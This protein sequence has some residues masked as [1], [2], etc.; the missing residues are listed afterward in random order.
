MI[1]EMLY[2]PDSV[3]YQRPN[4][5]DRLVKLE[6][7]EIWFESADGTRLNGWWLPAVG[8]AEGTVI[9]L[10]GNAQNMTSHFSFVDWI[11]PAGF[12]LLLFDYRGYGKSKGRPNRKGVYEDSVA[13][14]RYVKGREDV[15]Q[16]KIFVLGQSLGGT[17]A[18]GVM[19]REPFEGIR[20]VAID[21]AFES[22]RRIA[23]DK[24]DLIPVLSLAK[25]PMSKVLLNDEYSAIE[26]VDKIS[27]P[28]V[29]IHAKDD[30]VVPFEHGQQLYERASEP[31]EF[32]QIEQGGHTSAFLF[33]SYQRKLADFFREALKD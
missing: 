14:L 6:Y 27:V 25:G 15:E 33:S 10:H 20:A 26:V 12:N 30:E 17:C 18:L 7:E 16:D 9:H 22:Y 13:A 19:G 32:W 28:I 1:D 4:D 24:I 11:P 2:Y 23:E 29:F 5:E 21:S 3:E 31:K 8:R